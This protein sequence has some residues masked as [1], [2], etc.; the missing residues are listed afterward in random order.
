[1]LTYYP[2]CN[3]TKASPETAKRLSAY[4]SRRMHSAGCCRTDKHPLAPGE[5]ALY[6]CQACR[7]VLSPRM[8]VENLYVY[9]DLDDALSLPSYQGLEV[10]LQDCWR[11]RDHPEIQ[12]AVRSLLSK[13][14]IRWVDSPD[15]GEHS[16]FCGNL[17]FEPR[18]P[19]N[20]AR[21]AQYPGLS[22][23]QMPPEVQA[24]LMAEQVADYRCG[25][26]VAYCNRCVSGIRLGGGNSVHLLELIFG[27]APF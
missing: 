4:L 25:W 9:L 24:D 15:G 1:M 21:M 12:A 16:R 2:S 5:T 26:A 23:Q 27:D 6:F 19:E 13:M 8:P 7:E 14:Q 22:I 17:H 18:W 3:F 20:L 11:D 10:D